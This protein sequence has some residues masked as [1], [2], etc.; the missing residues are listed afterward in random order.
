MHKNITADNTT[1]KQEVDNIRPK[2]LHRTVAQR[3][4]P[5]EHSKTAQRSHGKQMGNRRKRDSW[6]TGP[7]RWRKSTDWLH[8]EYEA[9]TGREVESHIERV[10]VER[11]RLAVDTEAHRTES[12]AQGVVAKCLVDAR[13]EGPQSGTAEIRR[14]AV[15]SKQSS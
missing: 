7:T 15:S 5:R 10:T 9:M 3:D 1:E 11:T 12:A 8:A 14:R 13:F 2:E 4:E 6:R